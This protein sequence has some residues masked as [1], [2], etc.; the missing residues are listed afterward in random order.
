MSSVSSFL[1]KFIVWSKEQYEIFGVLLVGSHARGDAREDSDVDLVIVTN[2]PGKLL[3]DNQWIKAFGEVREIINGDY[4]LVQSKRA[5]FNDGL[6]VE[7]GITTSE[8]AKTDPIDPGTKKVISDG[9]KILYD[10]TE[11]L[12]GLL[13]AF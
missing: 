5:Y 10:K 3:K 6:E 7:F 8:W 9:S 1:E 13:M 11:I 12:N 4:G 2:Y